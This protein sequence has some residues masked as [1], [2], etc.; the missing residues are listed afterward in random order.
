MRRFPPNGEV[1]QLLLINCALGALYSLSLLLV[2]AMWPVFCVRVRQH[3]EVVA[4][5]SLA[6]SRTVEHVVSL[7]WAEYVV[8]G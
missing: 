8:C 7:R 4:C 5:L 2:L 1:V 6:C 3:I